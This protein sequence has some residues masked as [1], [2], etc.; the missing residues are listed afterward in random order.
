MTEFGGDRPEPARPLDAGQTRLAVQATAQ[1][2]GLVAARRTPIRGG[3]E[4]AHGRRGQARSQEQD[5]EAGG[6]RADRCHVQA[7]D[8][9]GE[10]LAS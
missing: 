4:A 1:R 10:A 7:S 3:L 5:D 2:P 9:L 8:A 6:G